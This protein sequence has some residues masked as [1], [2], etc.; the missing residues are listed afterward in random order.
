MSV[1]GFSKLNA[2]KTHCKLKPLTLFT[3]HTNTRGSVLKQP[4]ISRYWYSRTAGSNKSNKPGG[5]KIHFVSSK[6]IFSG[7]KKTL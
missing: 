7:E 2:A 6:N 4:A 5:T 1:I 3:F